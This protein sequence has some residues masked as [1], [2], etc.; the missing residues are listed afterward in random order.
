MPRMSG[1]ELA[2]HAVR[3]HPE[4]KVVYMSGYADRDLAAYGGLDPSKTIIPKPFKPM[5]LVK[6][7]REFLDLSEQK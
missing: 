1:L 2:D 4:M 5:D 3:L 7:V 6:Q